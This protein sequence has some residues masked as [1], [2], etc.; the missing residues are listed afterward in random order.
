MGGRQRPVVSPPSSSAAAAVLPCLLTLL[1][2][3][4]LPLPSLVSSNEEEDA[5]LALKRTFRDP[6][7]TTASWTSGTGPCHGTVDGNSNTTSWPTIFCVNGHVTQFNMPYGVMA[8]SL[9]PELSNLKELK[10]MSLGNNNL[11]GAIP[12]ELGDM[13]NLSDLDLNNNNLN[14]SI[15]SELCKLPLTVLLLSNNSLS[16]EIPPCLMEIGK[17]F[18]YDGN[19]GLRRPP[20]QSSGSSSTPP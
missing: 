13:T 10:I 16:G 7:G 5:L 4:L 6:G 19:P 11:S 2:L 3:S 12:P 20:S 1:L 18:T 17:A 8:G 9:V 14:G 15:P